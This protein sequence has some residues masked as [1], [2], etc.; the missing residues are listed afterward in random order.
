MYLYTIEVDNKSQKVISL[1]SPQ[2]IEGEK[3]AS[4]CILGTLKNSN[5]EDDSINLENFFPNS[6]FINFFHSLIAKFAPYSHSLNAEAKRQKKGWVYIIDGRCANPRGNILPEDIIGAFKVD[7]SEIILDSYQRNNNHLI[8]SQKG[9]FKLEPTLQK[10]LV[11][12]TQKLIKE[13]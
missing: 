5:S 13:V 8:Y 10:H 1:L 4:Q 9:F 6:Q 3:L 7:N 11:E 12:E 2:Q